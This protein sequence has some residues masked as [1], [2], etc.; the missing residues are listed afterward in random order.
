VKQRSDIVIVGELNPYGSDPYFAM[1]CDPPASAG[2]RMQRLVCAL[3]RHA[4]L[5]LGRVNLC[6][7][8]WSRPKARAQATL[9]RETAPYET[10]VL[11]GRKVAE[12]FFTDGAPMPFNWGVLRYPWDST[13]GAKFL[14]LPHPSGLNRVWNE[15]GAF[16][17]ARAAL[18]EVAPL[19]PWGNLAGGV[20]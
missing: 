4:Y 19:V 14:C 3:E 9:L 15:V 6:V 12:S 16:E 11:L 5:E 10:W 7:G 8:K 17:R 13:R 1:Y 18:R 2:G 20:E